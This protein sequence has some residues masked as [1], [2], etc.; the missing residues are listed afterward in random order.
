MKRK[1]KRGGSGLRHA[2][3]IFLTILL[4][5]AGRYSFAQTYFYFENKIIYP[6]DSSLTFYTL[7]SFYSNGSGLATVKYKDPSSG[8]NRLFEISLLDSAGAD[9]SKQRYLVQS[10]EALPIE[11]F[12]DSNYVSPKFV[13][14]KKKEG[15]QTFFEPSALMYQWPDGSWHSSEMLM[16][17]QMDSRELRGEDALVL[18]FYDSDSDFYN[19]LHAVRS[20]PPSATARKEK[21]YLITVINSLDSTIGASADKDMRNVVRLFTQVAQD[22][23]MEIRVQ[24]I[25]DKD[26]SKMSVEVALAKLQPSPIDVVLFYYSGHGFRYSNDASLYPRM[27]FR[28]KSYADLDKNN[29]S[30]EAVYKVLVRKKAKVTLVLADCCNEDIGVPVPLAEEFIR[31]KSSNRKPP[32]NKQLC[33]KLFFPPKP[34]SILIGAADKN[35]LAVCSNELGG[36][37]THS[38]TSELETQFYQSFS[39]EGTWRSILAASRKKAFNRSLEAACETRDGKVDPR[40][41]KPFAPCLQMARFAVVP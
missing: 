40:T 8:E 36:Y 27:S 33:K 3:A 23:E 35:Q 12:V 34:V 19:R 21:F 31:M 22:M 9:V 26:F 15:D 30:L 16:N 1:V 32:L 17:K 41:G 39:S 29:L 14:Q 4:L 2:L 24:R 20:T 37:F 10:G 18:F 11:G 13:F 25:M 5:S 7:M 6:N 38:L 28:T